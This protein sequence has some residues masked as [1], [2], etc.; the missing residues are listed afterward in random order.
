MDNINFTIDS[1]DKTIL[2]RGARIFHYVFGLFLLIT[3]A[4]IIYRFIKTNSFDSSFYSSLLIFLVGALWIIRGFV[5]RDFVFVRKYISLTNDAISLKKPFK[6][7]V[8]VA[9][10]SIVLI[11]IKSSKLDIK[12]KDFAIDFD[13]TWITF[14]ELQQL[15]EK[16]AEFGNFN[17]IEIK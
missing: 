16:F 17:K 6:N 14:K 2:S 10:N 11:S 9:Q 4:I 8:Q 12:T 3:S 5:G 13:L 7:E 15:R 1:K